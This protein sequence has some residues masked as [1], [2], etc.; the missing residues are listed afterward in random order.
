MTEKR[1][2]LIEREMFEIRSRMEPDMEDLA[3]HV[4]PQ[5]VA[6]QV[7]GKVRDRVQDTTERVKA[8][9]NARKDE[10]A[11]SA[12]RQVNLLQKAGESGETAPF[13]DAVRSDPRPLVVLAVVLSI[14]LLM[15]RKIVAWARRDR[16]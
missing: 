6:E 7:K 10:F 8:D 13:E 3:Q 11:N 5:H 14:V 12:R 15:V 4:Q 9:L 2:E 1:P 16:G